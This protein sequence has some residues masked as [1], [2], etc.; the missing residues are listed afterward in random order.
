MPRSMILMSAER[1]SPQS[2]SLNAGDKL[3]LIPETE[4]MSGVHFPMS[5]IVSVK[6]RRA[7]SIADLAQ[8][9][10]TLNRRFPQLRLAYQID[11]V[12]DRLVRVSDAHLNDYLASLVQAIDFGNKTLEDV[13]SELIGA[14]NTPI[15]QPI[16]ITTHGPYVIVRLHHSFGDGRFLFQ[17]MGYLLTA[18]LNPD[19]FSK[20]PELAPHYSLPAWRIIYQ[21]PKQALRVFAKWIR[22]LRGSVQEYQRDTASADTTTLEPI[23]TGIPQRTAFRSLSPDMMARMGALRTKISTDEK[24]SLNTLLQALVAQVLIKQGYTKPPVIYSFP[25]DLHRYMNKPDDFYPGNL[26]SQ[27]RITG[28][29]PFDLAAEAR[30][31]Q[32][33][34]RERLED[35]TGLATLPSEW[36]LALAGRKIYKNINRGWLNSSI[37]SDPRFFVLSNIGPIDEHFKAVTEHLDPTEGIAGLVPLM[38]GPHLVVVVNI[39]QGQSNL[40]FTFDPRV[41]TEAQVDAIFEGLLDELAD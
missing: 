28:H 27:L 12:K 24:V 14:N 33:K 32:A 18:L 35:L 10:I 17:L 13:L 30:F 2:I 25:V 41:L 40:V 1:R 5:V 20:L 3:F 34:I 9:V 29:A 16:L 19:A 37:N 22:D 31:L 7:A 26:L 6:L 8:A 15:T 39:F 21:T 38:G 4:D 11:P 36:L 23:R